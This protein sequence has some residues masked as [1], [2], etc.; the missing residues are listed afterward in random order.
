MN[1]Q[2]IK[3]KKRNRSKNKFVFDLKSDIVYEVALDLN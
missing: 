1:E 2:K 3:E